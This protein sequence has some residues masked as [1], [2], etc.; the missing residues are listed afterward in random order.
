VNLNSWV[1][2][3]ENIQKIETFCQ[4]H[5]KAKKIFFA[6]DKHDDMLCFENIKKIIPEIE[7]YDRT[8]HSLL[9]TFNVL[10][11]SKWGIW[12]RLHFLLALQYFNKPIEAIIY[13][14]KVRKVI[15]KK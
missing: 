5:A 3:P 9:E 2:N 1:N 14:D 13:A 12:S 10:K 8:Q 7:I 4:N 15:L 6:S 11:Y